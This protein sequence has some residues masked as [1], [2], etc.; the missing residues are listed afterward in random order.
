MKSF[1]SDLLSQGGYN[2]YTTISKL[3]NGQEFLYITVESKYLP[4]NTN[5]NNVA[6]NNDRKKQSESDTIHI[7]IL[8][9]YYNYN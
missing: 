7:K 5:G 6:L 8:L 4:T 1:S 2:T 3:Q 9:L